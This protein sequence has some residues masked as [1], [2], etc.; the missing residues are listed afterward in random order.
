MAVPS[1]GI[2]THVQELQRGGSTTSNS[3][4]MA[5]LLAQQNKENY[6]VESINPFWSNVRLSTCELIT[7]PQMLDLTQMGIN[8]CVQMPAETARSRAS[9]QS[10]CGQK[11]GQCENVVITMHF[12]TGPLPCCQIVDRERLDPPVP[13]MEAS[14]DALKC[15]CLAENKTGHDKNRFFVIVL[16]RNDS[17]GCGLHKLWQETR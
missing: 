13:V 7:V 2:S 6:T 12:L 17:A 8:A 14:T 1:I 4:S 16:L 15:V 9:V 10:A 3:N 5:G 11:F